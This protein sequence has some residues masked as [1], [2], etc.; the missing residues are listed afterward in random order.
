MKKIP[1]YVFIFSLFF[2]GNSFS[3]NACEDAGVYYGVND[4]YI[5]FEEGNENATSYLDKK[6]D[7][8]KYSPQKAFDKKKSTAWVEGVDG[9]GIQE[10]IF[11][12][13]PHKAQYIKIINGL[14]LSKKWFLLNNRVKDFHLTLNIYVLKSDSHQCGIMYF[15]KTFKVL[16]LKLNDSM[17]LQKF[18]MGIDHDSVKKEIKNYV[19]SLKKS[20]EIEDPESEPETGIIGVLTIKDVYSGE[21][22]DDTCI[23]A[24]SFE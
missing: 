6:T 22:Y 3:Q 15:Y 11:F 1:V 18:N 10:S 13:I 21:K 24:I 17:S 9:P 23:S 20:G 12:K 19:L 8:Y 4:E 5:L 14:A 2:M 16:K 7:H